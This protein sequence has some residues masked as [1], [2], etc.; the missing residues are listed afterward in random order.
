MQIHWESTRV[1]PISRA[2]RETSPRVGIV[3]LGCAKLQ[4]GDIVRMEIDEADET[5]M[6]GTLVG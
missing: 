5:D 6:W 1:R 4:Q 2:M 3:G